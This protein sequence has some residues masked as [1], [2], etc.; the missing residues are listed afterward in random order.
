MD[1]TARDTGVLSKI[2]GFWVKGIYRNTKLSMFYN[3]SK[4]KLYLTQTFSQIDNS[5]FLLKNIENYK[6]YLPAVYDILK[7][8]E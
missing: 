5:Y 3:G 4:Y 6:Q 8:I 7:Y 1:L 2:K